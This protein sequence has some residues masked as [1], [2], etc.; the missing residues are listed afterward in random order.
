MSALTPS[1]ETDGMI[2]GLVFKNVEDE[3]E[4]TAARGQIAEE[5]PDVGIVTCESELR[6]KES[7]EYGGG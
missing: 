4:K 3:G 2:F 5:Q 6:N 1:K 7:V